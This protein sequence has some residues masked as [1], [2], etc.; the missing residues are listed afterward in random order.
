MRPWLVGLTVLQ[1]L[2]GL[3]NVV[4][5]WPLVAAVLHTG[6]AAAIITVLAWTWCSTSTRSCAGRTA[7]ETD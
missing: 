3:S 6:G 2:T 4:L 7:K 5:D 1:F